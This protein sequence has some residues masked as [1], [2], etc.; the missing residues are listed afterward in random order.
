MYYPDA[1]L[2]SSSEFLARNEFNLQKDI[3]LI[4]TVSEPIQKEMQGNIIFD[5]DVISSIHGIKMDWNII[6]DYLE[7][8]H[9]I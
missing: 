8:L 7:S 1:V 3:V 2:N 6:S 5:I 4:V 9:N